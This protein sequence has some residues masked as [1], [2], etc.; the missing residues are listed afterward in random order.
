[1]GQPTLALVGLVSGI[2]ALAACIPRDAGYQEARQLIADRMGYAPRWHAVDPGLDADGETDTLLKAPLTADRA[3]RIALMQSPELQAAFED[4]GLARADLVEAIR[5]PNPTVEGH[6]HVVSQAEPTEWEIVGTIDLVDLLFLPFRKDAADEALNAAQARVAGMVLE[7][8]LRVKAAFYEWKAAEQM[9]ELRR[10]VAASARAS[11]E[12]AEALHAA[13]NINDFELLTERAQY[14]DARLAA[15]RS[16]TALVARREQLAMWMGLWG[17]RADWKSAG[18]LPD[19]PER[20]IPLAD[21]ERRALEQ[22]LDLRQV[23]SDYAAAARRSD[24]AVAEAVVPEL[25][26]GVDVEREEEGL[27]AGPIVELRVPLFYQGQGAMARADA[28]MRR[29][30]Q[31]HR[32]LAL[33]IRAAA[34]TAAA[35]LAAARATAEYYR[36][37]QLPLRQRLVDEA[38]LHYNAMNLGVSQLLAARSAQIETGAGYVMALRDYWIARAELETLLA[39]RLIDAGSM[40][41]PDAA[42]AAAAPSGDH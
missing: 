11:L 8:A 4:L 42:P 36:E 1:M 24:L 33:R 2:A 30:E 10:T 31:L 35:K 23:K 19:V 14:E 5:L 9:L 16:E 22:S 15:A 21:V 12:A 13:D 18:R 6:V 34:R 37:V 25:G 7:R 39:G 32:G 17:T 3:V 27:K 28:E 26:V 29:A 41:S 38:Q 20:E 40:P